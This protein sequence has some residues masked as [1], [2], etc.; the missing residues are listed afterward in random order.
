M[1]PQTLQYANTCLNKEKRVIEP[2]RFPMICKRLVD[3][4]TNIVSQ[5]AQLVVSTRWCTKREA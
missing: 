4:E 1:C 2:S 3:K 5:Q